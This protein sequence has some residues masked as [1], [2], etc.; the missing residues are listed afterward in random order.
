MPN[1]SIVPVT[2]AT[3]AVGRAEHAL[4]C[5]AH[6]IPVSAPT[7]VAIPVETVLR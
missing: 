2:G 7:S 1:E 5:Q 3:K 6:K 4:I